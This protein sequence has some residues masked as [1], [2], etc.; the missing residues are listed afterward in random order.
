[1]EVCF[2][3]TTGELL[4]RN[5]SRISDKIDGLN[6]SLFDHQCIAVK[7]MLDLEDRR[8]VNIF[9]GIIKN[10]VYT[11]SGILAEPFGAG[12][13]IECLALIKSRQQPDFKP[14][15]IYTKP[16]WR[17]TH[18]GYKLITSGKL[19][20]PNLVIIGASVFNQWLDC[21]SD[22]SDLTI[23]PVYNNKTMREF[24]KI[25]EMDM[26][27]KYDVVLVKSGD[28]ATSSVDGVMLDKYFK[29]YNHLSKADVYSLPS[30][31]AFITPNYI[32]SRVIIDDYDTIGLKTD[33]GASIGRFNWYISATQKKINRMSNYFT[34]KYNYTVIDKSYLH[35]VMYDPNIQEYITVANDIEYVKECINIYKPRFWV[36]YIRREMANVINFI[37]N[38]SELSDVYREMINSDAIGTLAEM[39]GLKTDNIMVIFQKML[40]DKFDKYKETV[41]YYENIKKAIDY[42]N[43]KF[44]VYIDTI[45]VDKGRV[46]VRNFNDMFRREDRRHDISK[47]DI[48]RYIKEGKFDMIQFIPDLIPYLNELA[49]KVEQE[50]KEQ[51]KALQRLRNNFRNDECSIC[52]LEFENNVF[53]LKCCGYSICENCVYKGTQMNN[54]TSKIDGFCPNCKT[55]IKFTDLIALDPNMDIKQLTDEELFKNELV[56]EEQKAIEALEQQEEKRDD[57]DEVEQKHNL[58]DYEPIA[59]DRRLAAIDR[60]KLHS[61]VRI[62]YDILVGT[63]PKKDAPLVKKTDIAGALNYSIINMNE[64]ERTYEL[65]EKLINII[66]S[67]NILDRPLTEKKKII[68][69]ANYCETLSIVRNQLPNMSMTLQGTARQMHLQLQ[70]FKNNNIPILLINSQKHCAG[71][72]IQFASD[73]VFFHKIIDPALEAQVE[74]RIQRLGRKYSANIH[75]IL[76]NTEKL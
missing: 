68:V 69:F 4:S 70:E 3:D 16:S 11:S 26:L 59:L 13:T 21:I 64:H 8:K 49:D 45:N 54:S 63:A 72:N 25:V 44:K 28:T 36:H 55:K 27:D 61:K 17:D 60:D 40:S 51:D 14:I 32:W 58:G 65:D 71:I 2:W 12:K 74:G 34:G 31:V 29:Y 23:L 47:A 57:S 42:S 33:K 10:E 52:L 39:L 22:N 38:N 75:F 24:I 37:A 66:S 35:R 62:I 7:A 50:I 18:S 73:L 48:K 9:Y 56:K 46:N 19:V 41:I 76:Y 1:M 6:V 53:V 67:D 30:C 20:R 43:T 5:N 15:S